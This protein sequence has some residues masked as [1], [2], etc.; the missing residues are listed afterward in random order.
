MIFELLVNLNMKDQ[1]KYLQKF[2]AES[3][4]K[5]CFFCLEKTEYDFNLAVVK[6]P[7]MTNLYKVKEFK[8]V[9]C[10]DCI[11]NNKIKE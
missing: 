7:L 2:V 1:M 5:S 9:I 6:D 8:H 4:M 11:R 3:F 10:N